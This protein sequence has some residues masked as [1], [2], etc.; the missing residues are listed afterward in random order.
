MEDWR[1]ASE[2]LHRATN[3][4]SMLPVRRMCLF[5]AA[6]AESNLYRDAPKAEEAEHRERAIHFISRLAEIDILPAQGVKLL[7]HCDRLTV[8]PELAW[9]VLAAW[10]RADKNDKR[11]PFARAKLYLR[12]HDYESAIHLAEERLKQKDE[13][14]W[15]ELREEARAELQRRA[16]AVLGTARPQGMK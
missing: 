6:V 16:E 15:R 7:M 13:P 12:S 10:E 9:R 11:L 1:T 5:G 2:L 8:P 3:C 14:A 4:N